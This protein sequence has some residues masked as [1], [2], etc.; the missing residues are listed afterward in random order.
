VDAPADLRASADGDRLAQVLDNL[1]SNAL[2]H[3]GG[4]VRL[5]ASRDGDC[6]EIRVAD[7]GGGVAPLLAERLFERFATGGRTAGTGLGLFIVRELA[8]AQGGDARYEESTTTNPSGAFVL[9][10]PMA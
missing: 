6:V 5:A 3:G 2:R 1:V 9:T 8:R 10:L 7:A 4:P